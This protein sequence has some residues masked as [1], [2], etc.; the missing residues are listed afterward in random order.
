MQ[1]K[2]KSIARRYMF[3]GILFMLPS[4]VTYF[5]F[6]GY[7][8]WRTFYISTM[9]WDGFTAMTF[10]G[11]ENYRNILTDTTFRL[12]LTNTLYFSV[13]A[14]ILSVALGLILAWF[15]M[16]LFR[17]EGQVFR[18]LMFSPSMIAPTIT[19]LLFIFIFTEDLGLL[20]NFLRLVGLEQFTTAWLANLQTVRPS[21]VVAQVWRQFGFAMVIC[22]AGM[23]GVSSEILESAR[24]DGAGDFKIFT[25]ILIPLIRPQIEISMMFTLLW[26]LRIYDSVVSLTGGGPARQTVVVPMWI[27]DNAFSFSR[28]GYASALSVVFIFITLI[29]IV[30]MRLAFRG[31]NH[32][33]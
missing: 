23:Q 27:I 7:P 11:L 3:L 19:G 22:Y 9:R 1:V 28:H 5:I 31:G 12:A 17:I 21:V 32:E 33:H 20:N 4:L 24:L 18:T 15:N 2:R 25:R 8:L 26:G 14:A 30:L 6:M 13:F 10:I 16:Y 29:F